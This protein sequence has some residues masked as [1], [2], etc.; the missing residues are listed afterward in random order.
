MATNN[1]FPGCN[2]IPP[3]LDMWEAGGLVPYEAR[4]CG[5]PSSLIQTP[6]HL[7]QAPTVAQS[8]KQEG[9]PE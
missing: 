3:K 7:L 4:T 8:S 6:T 9:K 5:V 1:I 2:I